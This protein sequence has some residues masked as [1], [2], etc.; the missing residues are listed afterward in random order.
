MID[1]AKAKQVLASL[2]AANQA[3]NDRLQ[4]AAKA[5]QQLDNNRTRS[6]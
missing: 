4:L 6:L 5:K 1:T 3:Q 2:Q